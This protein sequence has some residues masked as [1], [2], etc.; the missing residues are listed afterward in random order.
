M[1]SKLS[2]IVLCFCSNCFISSLALSDHCR[3]YMIY[4]YRNYMRYIPMSY[5]YRVLS[6]LIHARHKDFTEVMSAKPV[7]FSS[8]HHTSLNAVLCTQ[9]SA[10]ALSCVCSTL[11]MSA[12]SLSI[13]PRL[14]EVCCENTSS[15]SVFCCNSIA[16]SS[17][18]YRG[19]RWT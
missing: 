13:T 18:L 6:G 8:V 19:E 12:C 14:A 1:S 4:V 9:S 10:S 17:K 3:S 11:R 2:F 16:C 15:F 7:P 5:S